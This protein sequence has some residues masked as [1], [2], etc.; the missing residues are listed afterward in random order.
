MQNSDRRRGKGGQERMKEAQEVARPL[1]EKQEVEKGEGRRK[2]TSSDA[3]AFEELYKV[4]DSEIKKTCMIPGHCIGNDLEICDDDIKDYQVLIIY[5]GWSSA[6][7]GRIWY[8]LRRHSDKG[9]RSSPSPS[10][11]LLPRTDTKLPSSMLPRP[12]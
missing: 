5:L 6:G 11:L 8:C 2:M 12:R 10:P 3:A 1:N 4:S 9:S 7:K